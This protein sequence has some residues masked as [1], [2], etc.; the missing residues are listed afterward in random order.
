VRGE[1]V[2]RIRQ[3][4]TTGNDASAVALS[5]S[6]TLVYTTGYLRQS[7]HELFQPVR[8]AA[9]SGRSEP[10][11]IKAAEFTRT[12]RLSPDGR[13]ALGST[14]DGSLWVFDMARGT[15]RKLYQGAFTDYPA[16]SP[17]GRWVAFTDYASG[18]NRALIAPLDGSAPPKPVFQSAA[19]LHTSDFTHDGKGLLLT[20]WP[21]PGE[22]G[23]GV[24]GVWVLP[25]NGSGAPRRIVSG[26]WPAISPDGRWIAYVDIEGRKLTPHVLRADGTGLAVP[27]A[28]IPA[29]EPR[30]ARDGSELYFRNGDEVVAVSV[31]GTDH[32]EF[33]E[34]Q[35]I[36]ALTDVR[37][38]D[39]APGT[40]EFV[41]LLR[42]PGSGIQTRIQLITHWS[43]TIEEEAGAAGR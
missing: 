31:K 4:S 18:K 34:P 10:L 25:L 11:R 32:P 40:R 23:E 42:S 39:P 29:R 14:T 15:G 35:R 7:L 43:S 16:W 6:G 13:Q 21:Q 41:G 36:L 2:A 24:V 17:D 22:V 26:T 38:Y 27:V 8:A 33:G 19:E 37:G 3:V 9:A 28:D 30:W 1:P 5:D 20:L 12:F